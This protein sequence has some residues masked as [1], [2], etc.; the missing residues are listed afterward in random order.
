MPPLT[1]NARHA[2]EDR[3]LVSERLGLVKESVL[4][5]V[6]GPRRIRGLLERGVSVHRFY[7]RVNACATAAHETNL[8]GII[9]DVSALCSG[10]VES[11][12]VLGGR[13]SSWHK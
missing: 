5:Y 7:G 13:C 12:L 11:C 6:H 1:W 4:R 3:K 10:V 2:R 9:R 8:R